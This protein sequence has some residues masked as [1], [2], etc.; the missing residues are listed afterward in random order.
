MNDKELLEKLVEL[1]NKL[2]VI[3]YSIKRALKKY[4]LDD[5]VER[6]HALSAQHHTERK[7]V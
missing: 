6:I 7:Q 1:E 2:Y 4:P 5:D 3:G